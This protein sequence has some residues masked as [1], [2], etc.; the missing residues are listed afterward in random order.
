VNEIDVNSLKGWRELIDKTFSENVA[1]DAK[2]TATNYRGEDKNFSPEQ[3]T[4]KNKNSYWATD[5]E[6]TQA[7][8]EIELP[9]E[10]EIKYV[11]MQEYI[12]LGQRVKKFHI[13]VWDGNEW[14]KITEGTTIGY[15]RI[16][17]LDPVK[18][19]RVKIVI[20]EARACLLLSNVEIY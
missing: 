11:L 10:K 16:V 1:R 15:K 14:K 13:E 12:R 6:V 3:A 20:D 8:L 7:T 2:V 9:E 17:K 18:T 4:D 19:S 5:D